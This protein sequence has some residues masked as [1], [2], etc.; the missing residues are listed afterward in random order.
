MKMRRTKF[1]MTG[2][3]SVLALTMAGPVFAQST[4]TQAVENIETVTVTAEYQGSG[5][6]KPITVPKER[7]T[8][9]QDFI[10][11]Q[12]AGQSVFD[13][14]NKVPGYNFT[15]NDPYGNSGGNVRIHGFDGNHISF[16]WDGMPLNDTG[17]YAI[18]TNQVADNE[19]IGS[20]S[21]N[22]GTTDV[23]SPTAAATGGVVSIISS[24]PNQEW[25]ALSDSSVG[26]NNYKRQFLRLDT[27]EIGPWHTTAFVSGSYTSYDKFKGPGFLKKKQFNAVIYQDLG[28]LGWIQLA[29]HWN[30]NRNNFYN[31][32]SFYPTVSTLQTV[33]NVLTGVTPFPLVPG[34]PGAPN[35]AYSPT[36]SFTGTGAVNN[37]LGFGLNW[38]EAPTCTRVANRGVADNDAQCSSFYAVR[39]NPSDTG[40]IRLSSLFH[41]NDELSLTVDPSIQ[42]VLANGGG[43]TSLSET[44]PRLAGSFAG[45]VGRDLN[46]DGDVLDNVGVYSPNNTNT[47]RYGLNTSLVWRVTQD[48]TVQLAYTGDF[49]FH[50]Q[51]GQYSLLDGNGRPVDPF[52]GYRD[53]NGRVL[54]ADGTPLRGR[55][56][57]SH[58]FLRQVAFDYEGNFWD[59]MVHV[60]AG[61]RSPFM[62]RDLNQ[63]CYL[64]VTGTSNVGFPTCTTSKPTSAVGA[65]GAVT[66]PQVPG[67][68]AATLASLY[69]PPSQET[70]NF[71]RVLPNAGI[72]FSPFGP[73]HQ[74]FMDYA[75]GLAA[76]RTDNL[77]NGGN[78][79]LCVTNG[80]SNP[81]AP[82]CIYSSFSKVNPETSTNYDIGYRFTSDSVQ[83]SI[84]LYNTQFKN[85]IVTSFDQEQG[86][87]I[88][89][90]IGS[91]NVAGV[92]AEANVQLMPELSVYTSASYTHSRVSGGPLAIILVGAGGAPINLAGKTLVET[93]DWT[94]SQRYEYKWRGLTVG[95]GGKFTG[96]RF[97]TDNNDFKTPSYFLADGDI[98]Y[99]LG[100]IGWTGSYLKVNGF[101]LFNEKYLGS[102]SSKPCFIPNLAST[103]ACG[104]L[105]TFVVGSPQ[106]FQITLRTV[107]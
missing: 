77:Y 66:L 82:G 20:A 15:N 21:V 68:S 9:T 47:I 18:F 2:A 24:R 86:I 89:R 96:S 31:N 38:D 30:S 25:G 61:V 16:T 4:G 1:L 99:D 32:P 85:R 78:N 50:R 33:N 65:N 39:I 45:I 80:A 102:I 35:L 26:T 104:S 97:A 59:D 54:S 55:D 67:A 40:N 8:I 57:R 11:T 43:Y 6:M 29:M 48:H 58:A 41:L 71:N 36:G 106:T 49:G 22:Q 79:G 107:L 53:I 3:S 64:Q 87:S 76:P 74:F 23:D 63:L 56:R 17:N 92:D 84:N 60:S 73:M 94:L 46:G 70:V 13:S 105:P 7:S 101:N 90:N 42:Y 100:E 28:D 5:I 12:P 98:T 75:E 88:D 34:G 95:L 51:T 72:T 10:T 93:P 81:N 91:V 52:A 69:V 14:L 37:V 83:A 44:D 19:V 27:G 62:T 103:S